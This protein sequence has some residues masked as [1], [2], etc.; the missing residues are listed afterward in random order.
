MSDPHS[1]RTGDEDSASEAPVLARVHLAFRQFVRPVGASP[2]GSTALR[3]R[4]PQPPQ[5]ENPKKKPEEESSPQDGK[6]ERKEARAQDEVQGPDEV[7]EDSPKASLWSASRLMELLSSL[8]TQ[9]SEINRLKGA[10]AYETTRKTQRKGIRLRKGSIIDR[11]A[12]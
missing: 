7:P 9:Q 11:K 3:D 8:V 2:P 5:D 12:S 1:R 10:T 6:N 4:A